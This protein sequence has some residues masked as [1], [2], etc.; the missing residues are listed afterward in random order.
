[1]DLLIGGQSTTSAQ[2]AVIGLN[3]DTPIATLA[4][5]NNNGLELDAQNSTI[6]SLL[7]NTLV[8]GGDTT[9]DILIDG[10][11]S[12]N[13][14]TDITGTL[15][16]SGLITADGGLTVSDGQTLTANGIVNLGDGGDAITLNGS[17]ITLTGYNSCNALN[18]NG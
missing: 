1:M 15:T 18:T 12:I 7:N 16:S 17:G 9:G 3:D 6:Q 5:G 11:T 14:A 13:G 8:L 4:A 2:F 10:V